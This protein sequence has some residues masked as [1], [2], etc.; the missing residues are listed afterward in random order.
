MAGEIAATTL[1]EPYITLA[2]KTDC[3][4]IAEASFHGT[5]VISDRVDAD[6]YAAF[7]RAVKEA[8]RRIN[9]DKRKYLQ[10]FIDYHGK[11][12]PEI[13]ALSVGDLR[14]SR[15]IVQDPAPIPDDELERSYEWV[16]GWGML[17]D[18]P[19]ATDLVDAEAQRAAHGAAE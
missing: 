11:S 5:E 16:R 4:I 1:T 3:R 6:T 14:T 9:E 18:T 10:Y 19:L 8:V 15:L 7:N 13:A 2:E 12:D 17:E